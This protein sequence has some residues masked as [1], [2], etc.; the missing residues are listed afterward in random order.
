MNGEMLRLFLGGP[1]V[2]L[3]GVG[4]LASL[5]VL[6]AGIGRLPL[7]TTPIEQA[8]LRLERARVLP[9]FWGAAAAALFATALGILSKIPALGLLNI[10][11]LVFA[12][13]LAGLGLGAAAIWLGSALC[14]S[15][16]SD[17]ADTLAYLQ[18][19]LITLLAVSFLPVVGWTL[20]GLA[21]AAGTGAVVEALVTRRRRRDH[22]LPL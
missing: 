15:V 9:I 11:L 8:V 19:G 4:C 7:L 22:E 1:F 6:A 3:F 5:A 12:L 17:R 20:A 18:T 10:L 16:D 2:L 14:Q 21:L 13:A